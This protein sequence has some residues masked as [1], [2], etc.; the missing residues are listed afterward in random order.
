MPRFISALMSRC[1][2]TLA[3]AGLLLLHHG[4]VLG[5]AAPTTSGYTKP[6]RYLDHPAAKDVRCR[7][8]I[9]RATQDLQRGRRVFCWPKT[10]SFT[11]APRYA[12]ELTEVCRQHGIRFE[13]EEI[14]DDTSP[15]FTQG[16]YGAVMD[17]DLGREFGKGFRARW[18][19]QADSLFKTRH[20]AARN[21]VH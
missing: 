11:Y 17:R 6:E 7:Q 9:A 20:P 10:Y 18:M 4:P 14:S 21:T 12:T 16:Y 1:I 13:Y 2:P 3:F 19:A 15:G 5:Q 8:E